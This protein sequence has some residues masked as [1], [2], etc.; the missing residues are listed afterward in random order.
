MVVV[1]NV[2][3]LSSTDGSGNNNGMWKIKKEIFPKH[4]KSVRVSKK[5]IKGRIVTNTEELQGLYLETY[6]HRL[7]HRPQA[8]TETQTEC[9]RC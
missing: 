6:R 9:Q 3:H 2:G 8:Q 5:N 7:R 1:E 4:A